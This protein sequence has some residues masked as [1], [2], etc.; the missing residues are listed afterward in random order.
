MKGLYKVVYNE[1]SE[2]AD[3]VNAIGFSEK[4]KNIRRGYS[5]G[6]TWDTLVTFYTQPEMVLSD[7]SP[8]IRKCPLLVTTYD[9]ESDLLVD[10]I[11]EKIIY[12]LNGIK[13]KI[14]GEIFVNG[15]FYRTE[16]IPLMWNEKVNAWNKCLVFDCIYK[17]IN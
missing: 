17:K 16:L 1:L 14:G 11:S 9:R 5:L 6:G 8:D 15:I 10:D 13:K 3:L 7:I 2:N 12:I 4:N